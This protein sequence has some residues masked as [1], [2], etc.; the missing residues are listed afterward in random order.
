MKQG[1]ALVEQIT[2]ILRHEM[3]QHLDDLMLRRLRAGV[4]LADAGTSLLPLIK[5]LCQLNLDWDDARWQAECVRYQQVINSSYR[6][7]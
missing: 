1:S 3:I 4:L 5:P 7:G 2:W 6:L